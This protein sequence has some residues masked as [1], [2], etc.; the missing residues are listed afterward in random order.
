MS[1]KNLDFSASSTVPLVSSK[2]LFTPIVIINKK[3]L[4]IPL[5]GE[6]SLFL[7]HLDELPVVSFCAG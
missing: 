3:W 6:N 5:Y 2:I 1:S 4:L 7:R